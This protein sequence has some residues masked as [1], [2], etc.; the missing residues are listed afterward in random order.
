MDITTADFFINEDSVVVNTKYSEKNSF[1]G[2]NFQ[3][4]KQFS[5]NS[6]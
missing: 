1:D 4:I 2:F 3:K 5:L 6:L